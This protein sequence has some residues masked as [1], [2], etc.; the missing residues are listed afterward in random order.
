MGLCQ[1]AAH[2]QRIPVNKRFRGSGFPCHGDGGLDGQKLSCLFALKSELGDLFF[3]GVLHHP[4]L[5]PHPHETDQA[6]QTRKGC[7]TQKRESERC[8]QEITFEESARYGVHQRMPAIMKEFKQF[9]LGHHQI[10]LRLAKDQGK[11]AVTRRIGADS[12]INK[13]MASIPSA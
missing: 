9:S 5:S 3:I 4:P 10:S 12:R 1:G 8:L 6:D 13:P 11:K 7:Q 2:Q